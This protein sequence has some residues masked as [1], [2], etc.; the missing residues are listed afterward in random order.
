MTSKLSLALSLALCACTQDPYTTVER[1]DSRRPDA[2]IDASDL[3]T[4]VVYKDTLCVKDPNGEVCDGRDNDC[5]GTIDNVD[6]AKLLADVKNCGACGKPCDV[7]HAFARCEQGKCLLDKCA[8]GYYDLN[9]DPADG[10]EYQCLVTNGGTEICDNLDNDCDGTVDDGFDKTS[11]LENCGSCGV[12]C[13][14]QHTSGTACKSGKCEIGPCDAGYADANG[15]G[16]DGCEYKCPVWP[17]LAKD[18]CDGVD[19]DCDGKIDED[20]AGVACGKTQGECKAGVTACV[21]GLVACQGEVKASLELCNGKD[22]DCDG[23]IDN[24]YDK[25]NDPRYCGTCVACSL[26]HAIAKCAKGVCEIAICEAGWIDL[27]KVHG[28]G[29]EY[30]CTPTGQEICDGLD[31]DCDGKTDAADPKMVVVASPCLSKGACAGATA[32]CQG[33]KGWVCSYGPDVE[34]KSCQDSTECGLSACVAGKCTGLVTAVE[35]RCDGK[36]NNCDGNVDEAFSDKGKPCVEKGKLGI[37]QGSG[38]FAC[39]AAGTATACNLTTPGLAAKNEECN[40]LDDDCDGLVD[41]EGDDGGG[42]G[43]VDAMVQVSRSYKGTTYSFYIYTFEAARPDA[44]ST[45]A[46][47]KTA[48]ACSKKGVLPWGDVTYAEAE[49]ACI[50]AGKRLC[51][52]TEWFL[53]CSGAPADPAGCTTSTGDGCYFPYGDTYAATTCNGADRVPSSPGP[54]PTGSLASCASPG[55]IY[56][57]SGN[58]KEWTNDPRSDGTP[59]DPD[60]YTVRGGSF[61]TIASGLRCDFTFA[62]LPPGF[63]YPNLGFRCCSNGPP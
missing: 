20:H 7:S 40:G 47:V 61:D 57:M 2:R 10:C 62:T 1:P 23:T 26:N 55:A 54:V 27:N 15:D 13:L 12:K 5:D 43:V 3:K 50:A 9:K 59:P 14:T 29:C 39:N 49:A 19:N 52:A 63:A 46:G 58:L 8:P 28:D 18:D 38:T 17:A 34:L 48:R 35:T 16:K 4:E 24:G 42:K 56:D 22:D 53:A 37:C 33:S 36:D 45:S 51:T 30:Q 41:E 60:G 31:N 11:D 25:Q 32:S 44:S 21:G 6:P